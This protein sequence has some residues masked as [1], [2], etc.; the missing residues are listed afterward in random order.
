MKESI[1]KDQSSIGYVALLRG[2]NMIGQ[3]GIKMSE[4]KACFESLGYE[5]VR[6]VQA[7]GNIIFHSNEADS[8]ILKFSIESA[9]ECQFGHRIS[10]ILKSQ[11]ELRSLVKSTPFEGMAVTQQTKLLVTFLSQKSESTL[12]TPYKSDKGDFEILEV[13]DQVVYAVAYFLSGKP[14]SKVMAFLEKEFGKEITTRSWNTILKLF[15]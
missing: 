12:T 1:D 10:V 8:S 3:K 4:I 7:S 2:V 11:S 6:S 5:R 15:S 13:N 9:L 14:S